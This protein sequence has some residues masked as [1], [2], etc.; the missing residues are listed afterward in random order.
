M[1]PKYPRTPYWPASP[2]QGRATERHECPAR[3]V[4]PEVVVTEKIDGGN[5]M[6]HRGEVYARSTAAPSHDGW[7]A[8]VRKHMAWRVQEDDLYLYGEDIYA[9]HSIE[10]D[11]IAEDRTFFAFA[12]RRADRFAS[13]TELES[14]ARGHGIPLVPVLYRGRFD[15]LAAIQSFIDHAHAC[16]SALGGLREGLVLRIAG[17]FPVSDFARNVCKSVRP[18]HVQTPQHWR[19]HWRRIETLPPQANS[20]GQSPA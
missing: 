3:F 1:H 2:S 18:N 11:A 13:F 8:M 16:P 10:Y 14:Y 5:T 7:M 19:R 20:G 9:V 6:I 12:I 15:S 4:G 17:S